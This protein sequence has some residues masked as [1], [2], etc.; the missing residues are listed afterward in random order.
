MSGP[1]RVAI[2]NA[3]PTGRGRR[4]ARRDRVCEERSPMDAGSAAVEQESTWR[5]MPYEVMIR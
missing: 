1:V 5:R 2:P 4:T 3:V